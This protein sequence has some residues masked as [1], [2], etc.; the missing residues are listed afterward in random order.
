MQIHSGY[1]LLALKQCLKN[2]DVAPIV[3][4]AVVQFY[5]ESGL[6][7]PSE[8]CDDFPLESIILANSILSDEIDF[9]P[10]QIFYQWSELKALAYGSLS[11][12]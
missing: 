2:H 4:E 6:D 5:T 9:F 11:Q 7:E 8:D 3:I 10:T 1:D 12:R